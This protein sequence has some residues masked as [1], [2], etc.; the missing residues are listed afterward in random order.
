MSCYFS[1]L[2][3]WVSS[4]NSST[5]ICWWVVDGLENV[6]A[7]PLRQNKKH[8][9][10]PMEILPKIP[11]RRKRSR[12][13]RGWSSQ[14]QLISSRQITGCYHQ[15][16]NSLCLLQLY[17]RSPHPCL[18]ISKKWGKTH[19]YFWPLSTMVLTLSTIDRRPPHPPTGGVWVKGLYPY[20]RF[21]IVLKPYGGG[22]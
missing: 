21:S 19:R 14:E 7:G 3:G 11:S 9:W 12:R 10:K 20:H 6:W 8:G 18:R 16:L 17:L 5:D 22:T 2:L 1:V 13:D 4:T 15:M